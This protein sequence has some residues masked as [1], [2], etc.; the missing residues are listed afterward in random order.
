[1]ANAILDVILT[2]FNARIIPEIKLRY[3]NDFSYHFSYHSAYE[4]VQ[5]TAS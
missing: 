1:M 3:I 5:F 2:D 4:L